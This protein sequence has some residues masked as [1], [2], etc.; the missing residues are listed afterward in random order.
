MTEQLASPP[1]A[2]RVPLWRHRDF[3]LFWGGQTA[4][5]LGIRV[6]GVALPLIAA[7][8]LGAGVLQVSLLT[9]LAWL[10]YLLLSLPAG[11]LVDRVNPRR[12]MVGCDLGRA[13]LMLAVPVA[14]LLGHLTLPLLY[15]VVGLSGALTV[16]F[17]V[18]YKT[19]LPRLVAP[20]QLVAGNARLSVSQDAA[21]LVGPTVGGALTGL[22]GGART[23]VG[24]ALTFVVSA[25]TLLLVRLP[26]QAEPAASARVPARA[27]LT[28][29]LGFVRR[30]PILL[31]ILACVTTSNFFAVATQS[32]EVVYL[33]RELDASPA[34][35]GAV[36]SLGA[37]GG[38]VTG[39]L[40]DRISRR[41]GSARVIW[42]AMAVPG[43][44][45]LLVPLARPG[46]G[47]LLY[48]VGLA[49]FSANAV[50]FNIAILSY[51]QRVT[52]PELLGRVTAAFL[53]ICFGAVPLGA[54]FGGTL[55]SGWGL[56]PALV[57]CALGTW[58]AAL[59]V[60]CSPLRRMRDLPIDDQAGTRSWER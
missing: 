37:V 27:A 57:V 21:Q 9:S 1:P 24:T 43:P 31:R 40:A 46:W 32:L 36:F 56:R 47:L 48:A 17:T 51:R 38:L 2:A 11:L 5:E 50:L 4:G 33:V 58:S 15:A 53:W 22:V 14:A 44:L 25:V 8:T 19:V 16:L 13:A 54:L 59:W 10:P 20:E 55:G 45:Y 3:A 30:H 41:I 7:D 39:A 29:G 6:S 35:V 12:L 18:A 23:V 52:P 26:A 28:E 49:A 60:V 34:V 42:V